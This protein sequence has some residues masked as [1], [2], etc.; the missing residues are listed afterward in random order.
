M[1]Q[2]AI[3]IVSDWMRHVL[4][5]KTQD[6]ELANQWAGV[7]DSVV[8][9]LAAREGSAELCYWALIGYCRLNRS[10][11]PSVWPA[12]MAD[13]FNQLLSR[14]KQRVGQ[15]EGETTRLLGRTVSLLLELSVEVVGG[16]PRQW[17][18][19]LFMLD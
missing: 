18:K 6:Q 8:I 16:H 15:D 12:G 7:L 5:R 3:Q 4:Q 14:I 9:P 17:D 13:T 19:Q 10:P 1:D 2:Q 11:L